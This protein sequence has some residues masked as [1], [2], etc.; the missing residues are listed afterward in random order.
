[1]SRNAVKSVR[2]LSNILIAC[3]FLMGCGQNTHYAPVTDSPQ[4]PLS[5]VTHHRVAR[6]E[7]LYSIA[8]RFNLDYKKLAAANRISRDFRIYPGQKLLLSESVTAKTVP[9]RKTPNLAKE[10]PKPI[11]RPKSRSKKETPKVTNTSSFLSSP[12]SM[13]WVWPSGGRLISGFHSNGGLNKGIDLGGKLG[14]PVIA[15]SG[16][17]VVYSGDGLR[18]YGKLVIVKHNEKYLSAYAHNRKLLV[19]EGA[20]VKKGQKIAEMGS[21]GTDSVKLHFEIRLNGKPTN[22]LKHL[23]KR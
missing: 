16:G 12:K 2:L 7:T 11:S 9:A 18:G 8:W 13:T 4:P 14:E 1:M 15:A 6:G 20:Y 23:P 22:P 5:K 10:L 3:L 17:K 19:K 21:T